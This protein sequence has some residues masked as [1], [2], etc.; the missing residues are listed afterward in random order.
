M[1]FGRFD[2]KAELFCQKSFV[3]VT[4]VGVFKWENSH[5]GYRDL[6]FCDRDL[7]NLA[8][9][10][11]HMNGSEIFMKERVSRRDIGNRASPV[12][13]AHIKTP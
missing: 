13:W 10:A 3:P 6:G 5:P 9:P 12:D 8:S 2:A 11:F 4:R 7:G 1:Y